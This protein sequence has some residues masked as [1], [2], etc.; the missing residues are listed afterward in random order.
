MKLDEKR[1]WESVTQAQEDLRCKDCEYSLKHLQQRAEFVIRFAICHSDPDDARESDSA[2][3]HT[4]WHTQNQLSLQAIANAYLET[5]CYPSSLVRAGMKS[6]LTMEETDKTFKSL[7]TCLLYFEK[8]MDGVLT[9]MI[10]QGYI[11]QERL[12]IARNVVKK[13]RK[14]KGLL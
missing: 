11:P 5:Y 14:E 13:L 7:L 1:L 9:T 12:R 3:A 2:M 8:D 10:D 6:R 4:V